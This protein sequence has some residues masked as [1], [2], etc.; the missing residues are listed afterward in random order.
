[1]FQVELIL[2][3]RDARRMKRFSSYGSVQRRMWSLVQKQKPI[4]TISRR[5]SRKCFMPFSLKHV[6][7]VT[8]KVFAASRNIF[9]ILCASHLFNLLQNEKTWKT[10]NKDREW[11][12]FLNAFCFILCAPSLSGY[13]V[14]CLQDNLVDSQRATAAYDWRWVGRRNFRSC[15]L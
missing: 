5:R 14:Q 3:K 12:G 6:N 10:R 2:V 1:M 7:R 15:L 9:F 11:F 8:T 13:W 4:V